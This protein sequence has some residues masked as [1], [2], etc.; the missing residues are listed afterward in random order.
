MENE[1]QLGN[2]EGKQTNKK[3]KLLYIWYVSDY[4]KPVKGVKEKQNIP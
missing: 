2:Q 3:N 4:Q 1:S